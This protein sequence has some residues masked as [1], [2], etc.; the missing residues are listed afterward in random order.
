MTPADA[1]LLLNGRPVTLDEVRT[2]A[3]P[4]DVIRA[5][6]A[7]YHP[8]REVVQA[9]Q[10]ISI[11]L[12]PRTFFLT[13]RGVPEDA[14]LSVDGE[15]VGFASGPGATV[16]ELP[17]TFGVHSIEISRDGSRSIRR[18][19]E[20][21]GPTELTVKLLPE[22]SRHEYLATYQTG[23]QP[24]QVVF[25]PD[26]S[27]I[28]V[29]LLGDDGMDIIDF[30]TGR[31]HHVSIP[32]H[33]VHL[34]FVE[35]VFSESGDRFYLSQMT[36]GRIHEFEVIPPPAEAE[37]ANLPRLLRSAT[38]GGRWPKVIALSP[39]G[40]QIAVSNWLSHDV[41]IMDPG[42][43]DREQRVIPGGVTPRGI[44]FT[45]GGASSLLVT[46]Y[47]SGEIIRIDTASWTPVATAE[48]SGSPRHI[49]IDGLNEFA[50]VSDMALGTVWVYDLAA[51]N[52][53]NQIP[54]WYNANTIDLTPDGRYLY[55]STRGPN[56][57]G[58]YGLRSPENGRIYAIRTDDREVVEVIAGGNQPTDL[59]VSPDGTLLAFSNFQDDTVEAYAIDPE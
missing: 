48:T 8:A 57:S 19:V 27:R 10:A 24:K 39:D 18:E 30:A 22:E 56:N 17:I 34:G 3:R 51:D 37:S 31:V 55:V 44:A 16:T 26:G 1:D 28:F 58:G 53:A 13:V 43:L 6:R 5:E 29:P 25:T 4:G 41:S 35:G 45:S 32:E 59:A 42:T 15:A 52:V 11:A 49:V 9:A 38:T 47:D 40:S 2:E 12:L 23:R 36:T 20:V 46:F 54:V 33:G 50:Y 21:N 7:G 14:R